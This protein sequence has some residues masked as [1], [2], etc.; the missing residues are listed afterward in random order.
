MI[1]AW[2]L[3]VRRAWVPASDDFHASQNPVIA[4][5]TDT[6]TPPTKA[7]GAGVPE[8]AGPVVVRAADRRD[9]VEDRGEDVRG[10]GEVG[11]RWVQRLARPAAQALERAALQGQR[12]SD[13][14]LSHHSSW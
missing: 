3:I 7:E 6:A 2:V 10:D 11:K 1:V 13:R 14:E 12:R 4:A 8:L 5:N 9:H